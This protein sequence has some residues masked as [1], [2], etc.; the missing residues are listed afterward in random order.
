[1]N[2]LA[3]HQQNKYEA[4]NISATYFTVSTGTVVIKCLWINPNLFVIFA[5]FV[6]VHLDLEV[7]SIF[8]CRLVCF[9]FVCILQQQTELIQY[10]LVLLRCEY[11]IQLK[12][13]SERNNILQ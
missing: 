8:I 4:L 3:Y 11:F 9:M 13:S 2:S 12:F 1:M 6:L 7:S 10:N 5:K